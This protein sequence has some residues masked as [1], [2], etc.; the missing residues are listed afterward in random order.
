MCYSLIKQRLIGI[1]FF[2]LQKM[3]S[4]DR[5]DYSEWEDDVL[6]DADDIDFLSNSESNNNDLVSTI[7]PA[8]RKT[9]SLQVLNTLLFKGMQ[10]II[11]QLR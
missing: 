2:Q 8:M 3:K 10:I 5:L 11:L 6:F 4:G 9:N 1:L 7:T